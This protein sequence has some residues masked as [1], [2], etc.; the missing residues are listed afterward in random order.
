MNRQ[1]QKP[2]LESSN[3][4]LPFCYAFS[5]ISCTVALCVVGG[6]SI[7]EAIMRN[8]LNDSEVNGNTVFFLA[9]QDRQKDMFLC[10]ECLCEVTEDSFNHKHDVCFR[11]WFGG[12][13]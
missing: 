13:S 5:G 1:T 4:A 11:C 12:V 10:P 3:H 6:F 9:D 8:P 7:L 2:K